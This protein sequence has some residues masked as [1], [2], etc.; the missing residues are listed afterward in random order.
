[1][2]IAPAL[3]ILSFSS[4]LA[5]ASPDFAVKVTGH[6]PSVI[7]IPGLMCGGGVWDS[8]VEHLKDRYT[9]YVLTLPGFAGQPPIKAP[10]LSKMRD[11]IESYVVDNKLAQPILIGHSL[12]GTL[13][14]WLASDQPTMF[15]AVVSL[16]GVPALAA[17]FNPNQ[18]PTSALDAASA[19]KARY[20]SLDAAR[21]AAANASSLPL[22]ITDP[23]NVEKVAV[24]ANRSDPASVGEAIAE[25]LQT[26][27]RAE[28]VKITEPLLVFIPAGALTSDS[29]LDALKARYEA[30]FHDAPEHK[31]ALV[32]KARH[33]V[34]LDA[35]DL[36]FSQLDEFLARIV[37]RRG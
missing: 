27:L 26:D 20:A 30:Q 6:G 23:K 28:V 17:L 32:P 34:M 19:I 21:F 24:E 7:L 11:E 22:L 5:K 9:C 4:R 16:D 18:A 10:I 13:A 1:M 12:G 25:M 2:L 8:T 36:F 33:F 31:L 15:S 37:R 35:P 3:I 29:A 14:L